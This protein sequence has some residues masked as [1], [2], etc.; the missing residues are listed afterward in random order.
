MSEEHLLVL[1]ERDDAL[2]LAAE[3]TELG[4]ADVRVHREAL[5]G[6]DDA[7]DVE[8]A[9]YAVSPPGWRER[10]SDLAEAHEGWYDPHPR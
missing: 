9:V 8:W 2:S 1:P 7:E 3:L 6:E 10:L 4:L 5:A